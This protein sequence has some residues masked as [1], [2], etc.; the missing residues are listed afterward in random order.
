MMPVRKPLAGGKVVHRS[1]N[2]ILHAWDNKA[3]GAANTLAPGNGWLDFTSCWEVQ[4]SASTLI[5]RDL[6]TK[7]Y[8]PAQPNT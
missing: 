7:Q 2:R 4:N 1:E 3:A 5:L 6:L 8:L